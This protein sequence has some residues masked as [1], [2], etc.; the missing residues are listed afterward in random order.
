ML[1]LTILLGVACLVLLV[2]LSA[3]DNKNTKLEV[4]N[5][6]MKGRMEALQ[7]K[8]AEQPVSPPDDKP[9]DIDDVM[10]AVRYAGYVPERND[11]WVRF[12]VQGEKYVIETSRLPRIHIMKE[13]LVDP[14]EWEMDLLK[15]AAHLMSDRLIMG[16]ALFFDDEDGKLDLRFMLT[17]M[18]RSYH[19]FRENLVPYL[20]IIEDGRARMNEIYEDL[21][22]E[23]R[24]AAL[25]IG[26]VPP[27]VQPEKKIMS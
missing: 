19:S 11:T 20:G 21:V 24:D 18:D 4:D 2:L 23:K 5:K 10:E 8:L 12:M 13:Y 1:A 25:T 14:G 26:P 16:K 15:H 6:L 17:A 7:E 9:L 27:Q 3:Q 22:K